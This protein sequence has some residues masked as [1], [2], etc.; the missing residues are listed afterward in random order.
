MKRENPFFKMM[1]ESSQTK[2]EN[3]VKSENHNNDGSDGGVGNITEKEGDKVGMVEI[4]EEDD[5]IKLISET[6]QLDH[7]QKQKR[8]MPK[9]KT[10]RDFNLFE[11]PRKI[12][13]H[14]LMLNFVVPRLPD[15]YG[16][17]MQLTDRERR[18]SVMRYLKGFFIRFPKI[19]AH[20]YLISFIKF[21]N[22]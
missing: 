6:F 17:R 15:G 14:D 7:V 9:A 2:P 19:N 13:L 20:S 1:A 3:D 4:D 18:G 10:I 12:D 5:T 11:I 16:I 21:F 8:D 22:R